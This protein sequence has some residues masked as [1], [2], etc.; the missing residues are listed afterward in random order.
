M[1]PAAPRRIRAATVRRVERAA[2]RIATAATARMHE[3]LDWFRALPA[4]Q[5]AWIG[6]VVQTG[7]ASFV[8]WLRAP[9]GT[10]AVT[11]DVFGA[12]PLEMTRAVT[13][14]H[15]VD[16]IRLAVDVIEEQVPE[17][18]EPGAENDLLQAA[19][20]FSREIAF[21]TARVYARAAE[22]RGA[23]DARQEAIVVDALLRDDDSDGTLASRAAALGW[24][25]TDAVAVA[26]GHPP[27]GSPADAV[28]GL[29]AAARHAGVDVL[30]AVHADRLVAVVGGEKPV[31]AIAALA[32]AFGPGSIVVGPVVPD[33]ASAPRSARAALAGLRAAAAAEAP[34]RVMAAE[35]LLAERA[36][37]GETEACTQL[38]D[39][40]YK[41]LAAAGSALLDTCTAYLDYGG[42]LEATARALFVHPNTVRYRLN[43]VSDLVGVAPTEARGAFILRVAIVLGRLA[44]AEDTPAVL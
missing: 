3:D 28:D 38:V 29:R 10:P 42:S 36:L 30:A 17:L 31:A 5:R 1:A 2:G 12:A 20:R 13:L 33:L 23:W 6:L 44:A 8:A 43:K 21:E 35:D 24:H 14:A 22:L 27:A 37:T 26:A 16:L 19:L 34:P 25:G 41:P 32:P 39:D 4:E 7:I 18:A 40:I 11:G 9:A 15:T